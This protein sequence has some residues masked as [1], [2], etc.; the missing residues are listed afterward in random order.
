MNL[1]QLTDLILPLKTMANDL[2][3]GK[4]VHRHSRAYLFDR[5]LFHTQSPLLLPYIEELEHSFATLTKLRHQTGTQTEKIAYLSERCTNQISA[6]QREITNQTSQ[7]IER[8]ANESLAALYQH[9]AQ[10]QIWEQRLQMMLAE[11]RQ[12]IDS[13]QNSTREKAQHTIH[14]LEQRLH[15]CQVAKQ[16]IEQQIST[17]ERKCQK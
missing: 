11:Q 16:K 8:D 1:N 12:H 5:V 6:I 14:A 2:D 17:Q 4:K 3:K 13:D 7:R 10:H 9:R 15:R